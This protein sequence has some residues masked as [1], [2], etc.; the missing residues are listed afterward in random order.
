MDRFIAEAKVCLLKR[1]FMPLFEA[2][3]GLS[4]KLN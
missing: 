1:L 3:L 4:A 2:S